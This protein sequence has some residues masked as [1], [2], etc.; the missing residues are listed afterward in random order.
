[1]IWSFHTAMDETHCGMV[2]KRGDLVQ[3]FVGDKRERT[4]MVIKAR[5]IRSPYMAWELWTVRWWEIE[6]DLRIRLWRSAERN[7]GQNVL[8][9]EPV[10]RKPRK[11][12][13]FEELMK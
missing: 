2:P 12:R 1:M 5:R 3:T 13:S 4:W 7:G 8:R 11:K 10:K 9:Y 6:P